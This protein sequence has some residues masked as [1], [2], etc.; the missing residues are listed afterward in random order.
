MTSLTGSD[1]TAPE[2]DLELEGRIVTASNA[3]FRGQIGDTTV[4]YKPLIGEKPLWD[5]PDRTLAR[6][7]VAAYLLSE[8]LGFGVV[9]LTW[10]RDGPFG[11]GMV[12]LW[13]ETA[14][15]RHPVDL[16][17]PDEADVLQD[18]GWCRVLDGVDEED[19]PVVLLHEDSA[20]LRRMAIF[21]LLANNADRKAGHI[22]PTAD[23]HRFGVDHGLT[24]HT[25]NKVRT[26]LWGWVAGPLSDEELAAVRR[27]RDQLDSGG[28]DS[29]GESLGEL[30]STA[31]VTAVADR[32]DQLLAAGVF[33]GPQP[34]L[35]A[36]PWPVF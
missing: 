24:F 16:V 13:C 35:P 23:G 12:Q 2:G 25:Q 26:V 5:F 18:A 14:G 29:L 36:V 17:S 20:A 7:E 15:G 3:T 22:L 6:R 34:G 4:V 30:L 28:D 11:E 9:P 31:E 33:P 10:L 32:C 27:V 8:A 19:E 21:D 1:V